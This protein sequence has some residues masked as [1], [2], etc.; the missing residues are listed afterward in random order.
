MGSEMCIR[1]RSRNYYFEKFETFFSKICAHSER[2]RNILAV[3]FETRSFF[4]NIA[5]P[6]SPVLRHRSNFAAQPPHRP[7][8]TSAVLAWCMA[9]IEAV[10]YP[11]RSSTRRDAYVVSACPNTIIKVALVLLCTAVAYTRA[12]VWRYTIRARPPPRQEQLSTLGIDHVDSEGESAWS[13]GVGIVSKVYWRF[14]M[15]WGF[16]P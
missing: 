3:I 5:F 4:G 10:V 12:L 8:A 7:S 16:Q 14:D 13:I 11:K 2:Y 15:V 1:D 6:L 9:I